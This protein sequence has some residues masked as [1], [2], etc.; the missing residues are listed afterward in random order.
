[1]QTY[2]KNFKF[3]LSL[4]VLASAIAISSC[5]TVPEGNNSVKQVKGSDVSY[6]QPTVRDWT[7]D[8]VSNRITLPFGAKSSADS[9]KPETGVNYNSVDNSKIL[10]PSNIPIYGTLSFAKLS[11]T[12]SSTL[13]T[14]TIST[15]PLDSTKIIGKGTAF[16]TDLKAGDKILAVNTGELLTIASIKDAL[17]L[18]VSNVPA[19]TPFI[20]STAKTPIITGDTKT[21]FDKELKAGDKIIITKTGETLTVSSVKDIKTLTVTTIPANF[22][23][24][25]ATPTKLTGLNTAFDKQLKAGD[26][27]LIQKTGEILTIAS[28]SDSTNLTVVT[29]PATTFSGSIA[30]IYM[31]KNTRGKSYGALSLTPAIDTIEPLAANA[32]NTGNDI[33]FFTSDNQ[34]GS[35]VFALNVNGN[36]V[37]ENNFGGTFIGNSPTFSVPANLVP[38]KTYLGKK[39]MYIASSNGS[40]YCI[41]TDGKLVSSIKVEDSFKNTSVV[42]DADNANYDLIYA[43]SQNGNFYRFKLD[44]SN[45]QAYTFTQDYGLKVDNTAFSSSPVLNGNSIYLGG[46]N[47]VLHEIIP[48]TGLPARSWDLSLYT[49]NG[50]ARITGVPYVFDDPN[51]DIVLV[52]AGGYLFRIVGSTVTQSPLLELTNGLNSRNNVFGTVF[53][54]SVYPSGS[55]SSSPV[56]K[57]TTAYIS[58]GNAVFEI[59]FSSINSFK[60]SARYCLSVSGRTDQS[61][62]NLMSLG[63]GKI[64]ISGT[65]LAMIDVNVVK[66]ASPFINYFTIP[67]AAGADSLVRYMP[68]N[69]FDFEGSPVSGINAGATSD[70]TGGN[71]YFTLDNGSVNVL[72]TP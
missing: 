25:D 51:G 64:A 69:E 59:D 18:T 27:I 52:P 46:E 41:N 72:A 43:A 31:A 53:N 16:D 56:V 66:N 63:N 24:S 48:N 8:R 39:L 38:Q 54:S 21:L 45:P 68:V 23:D 2:K 9:L 36:I 55:I 11:G 34:H 49:R 20:D 30:K 33:L 5:G 22:T 35:N 40:I 42:V 47:G 71:V 29:L 57:G 37:W 4:F 10:T 6:T 70:G 15:D 50:S 26:K 28:V 12:L 3:N 32:G 19:P 60:N 1:M 13:L 58:N 14:G 17:N 44:F 67:F 62:M 61:D 65:K 7:F